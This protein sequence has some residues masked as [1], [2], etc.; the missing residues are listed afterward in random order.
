MEAGNTIE[1]LGRTQATLQELLRGEISA[2]ETYQQALEKEEIKHTARELEQIA[3]DHRVAIE[4]LRKEVVRVGG[5]PED[6]SGLWGA[7]TK[8]ATGAAKLISAEATLKALR[9]G[10]QYGM[11]DYENAL[12]DLDGKARAL[13][14]TELL[15][16]QRKHITKLG[17]FI[18]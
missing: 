4:K 16:N 11:K 6:T 2:Y 15:P 8:S 5:S 18:H 10:E 17:E 7:F 13:V 1:S 3:L 14:E 9:Q 12:Q